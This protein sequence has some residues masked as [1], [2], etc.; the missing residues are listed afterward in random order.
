MNSAE[1]LLR[2]YIADNILFSNNGYPHAD[3]TSFLEN[4]IVD[5]MNVLELVM[6][7]EQKF[8]V[9]VE[10]AEIVPDNFDSIAKL[11]AF[12]RRKQELTAV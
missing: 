9:K 11:A 5:S 7:V 12:I 8:G 3:D 4:G 10:D 2:K 1:E 6:F